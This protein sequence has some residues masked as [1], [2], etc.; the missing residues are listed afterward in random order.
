MKM[1]LLV[2]LSG[3]MDS[4]TA[5]A[6]AMAHHEVVGAVHFQYGAKH[7][8]QENIA[9]HAVAAH[10]EIPIWCFQLPFDQFKSDL[11]L[12][13]GDIP[14]GHYADESMKRTVVPFR[15]GIMLSFAAGLAESLGA[16]GVVLGNH[17]GDHAIYPDCREDFILAMG[18]AIRLGTYANIE[19]ISPFCK[20][21]KTGIAGIGHELGVPYGLTWTCYKGWDIH[22]GKCGSCTERKE[23]FK[24]SG[25]SDPTKYE[26]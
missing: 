24:D 21:D 7:N 9:A 17:F 12:S 23:A 26:S 6:W 11:L 4:A 18:S 10:Y 22:C 19:L 16:Q 20:I 2:V 5:L 13:G 1:K 8:A 3:G 15:N 14:E 25:T